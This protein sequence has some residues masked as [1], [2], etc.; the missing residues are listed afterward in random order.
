MEATRQKIKLRYPNTSFYLSFSHTFK[1][2]SED[3]SN[4]TGLC[5]DVFIRV[6][7]SVFCNLTK[8]S[9]LL[10]LRNYYTLPCSNT[11]FCVQLACLGLF[12]TTSQ[13]LISVQNNNEEEGY[14]LYSDQV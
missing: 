2:H 6:I 9:S 7:C 3:F 13:T 12:Q 4:I 10:F 5:P 1:A 8:Q 11:L 14:A